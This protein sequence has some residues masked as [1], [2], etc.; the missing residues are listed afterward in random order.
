MLTYDKAISHKWKKYLISQVVLG[1][2]SGKSELD[3]IYNVV[4]SSVLNNLNKGKP[5]QQF[6]WSI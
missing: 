3:G 6:L 1:F 5:K 2:T 4:C